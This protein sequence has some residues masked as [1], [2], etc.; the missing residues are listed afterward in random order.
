MSLCAL[1]ALAAALSLAAACGPSVTFSCYVARPGDTLASV[2]AASHVPRAQLCDYNRGALSLA[3]CNPSTA[4]IPGADVYIPIPVCQDNSLIF[5][6]LNVES[7]DDSWETIRAKTNITTA[8]LKAWNP[9]YDGALP[10]GGVGLQVRIPKLLCARIDPLS[11]SYMQENL[12]QFSYGLKCDPNPNH[13]DLATVARRNAL[14]LDVL[15]SAN[16]DRFE[17][18][19]GGGGFL[20]PSSFRL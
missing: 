20:D 15:A 6:C 7:S 5:S 19:F 3:D 17:V 8:T 13:D 1:I 14:S 4:L 18:G 2:A 16:A 12:P 11:T 10:P 9:E